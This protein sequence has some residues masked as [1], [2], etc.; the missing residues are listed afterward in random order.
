MNRLTDLTV[1]CIVKGERNS[2]QTEGL[3]FDMQL[4][5]NWK[6]SSS[7]LFAC[8]SLTPAAGEKHSVLHQVSWE[9]FCSNLLLSC[10]QHRTELCQSLQPGA[11][12]GFQVLQTNWH[13]LLSPT[14]KYHVV[15][16]RVLHLQI[17][18]SFSLYSSIRL[19]Q[20]RWQKTDTEN[21]RKFKKSLQNSAAGLGEEANFHA[22][23]YRGKFLLGRQFI[24][25]CNTG[26][27][28]L[29]PSKVL[30]LSKVLLKQITEKGDL[31]LRYVLGLTNVIPGIHSFATLR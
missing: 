24:P 14:S 12:S 4:K 16:C 10:W 18:K 20:K 31:F 7:P 23:I 17:S 5:N 28:W 2:T 13:L 29:L 1:R 15:L 22:D 9:D 19:K 3:S 27:L 26:S 21:R 6:D 11:R 8:Q 25:A 30:S